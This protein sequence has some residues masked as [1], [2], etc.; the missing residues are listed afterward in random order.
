MIKNKNLEIFF[1]IENKES[2]Y[3]QEKARKKTLLTRC[4]FEKRGKYGIP[5]VH[6]QFIDGRKI[7]LI[8]YTKAK[9]ESFDIEDLK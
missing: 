6:K 1:G 8:C 7:D 5:M 2:E 9:T 4:E 3:E